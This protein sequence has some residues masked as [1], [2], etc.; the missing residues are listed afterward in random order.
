MKRKPFENETGSWWK[1]GL[2]LL[3]MVLS[4]IAC[5]GGDQPVRI[6]TVEAGGEPSDAGVVADETTIYQIGDVISA[7]DMLLVVLGWDLPVPN[8][9]IVPEAGNRFIV[10]DVLVVNQ[11]ECARTL[12]SALQMKLKD[13]TGQQYSEDLA[14]SIAAAGTSPGGE[15]APGER[16]RGQVAYQVRDDS[17]GLVFVFDAD[18]WSAGKIFVE[19]GSEPI[20]FPPPAYLEGEVPQETFQIGD[21]VEAGTQRFVVN[22]GRYSS[23]GELNRP[24]AGMSFLVVDLAITNQGNRSAWFSSLLQLS[25]RDSS[26]QGYPLHLGASIAAGGDSPDGEILPGETVRGQVGFQV[27]DGEGPYILIIDTEVWGFGKIVVA[28]P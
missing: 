11:G 20:H 17:E 16:L 13:S 15:I 19:L 18:L 27:P 10:I 26:G 8:D 5:G 4:I 28:L 25:V 1:V 9:F 2:A 22:D 6:R 24:Q 7:G 21:I 14:A 3:V 12:A 23:G